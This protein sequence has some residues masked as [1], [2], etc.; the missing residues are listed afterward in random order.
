MSRAASLVANTALPPLAGW[1]TIAILP[2]NPADLTPD[3]VAQIFSGDLAAL[4]DIARLAA[5]GPAPDKTEASEPL[6]ASAPRRSTSAKRHPY[7]PAQT[8]LAA[9][10]G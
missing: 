5:T 1:Q 10:V 4:R 2:S 7:H 9:K 8:A 6:A 3:D